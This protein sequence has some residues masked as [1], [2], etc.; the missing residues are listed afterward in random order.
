MKEAIYVEGTPKPVGPYSQAVKVDGWIFLSGQIPVSEN[1]EVV[2]GDIGEES[3]VVLGN[4]DKILNGIGLSMEK[5]VKVVVYITDMNQFNRVN[6]VYSEFFKEPF[7]ARSC[8]SVSS[9]P[10]RANVMIDIVAKE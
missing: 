8:V 10:K 9:L 4:I 6:E 2:Q 3:R 1:G 7:P 5:V